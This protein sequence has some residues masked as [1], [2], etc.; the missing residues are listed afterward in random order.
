MIISAS[1]VVVD[2]YG[3]VLLIQRNDTWTLAPPGGAADI[4]ELPPETATR[5]VRE[6][7]GLIVTPVRLVGLYYL[8]TKPDS[9]LA[10][11]FRCIMRGGNIETSEESPH[12]GF[13]KTNPLPQ[14]MLKI[15]T[16]R[17]GRSMKHQGGAPYWGTDQLS[18]GMRLGK[19]LLNRMIYP[20]LN[21]R[22]RRAGLPMHSSPPTWQTEA[23]VVLP[24]DQNDIL[25]IKRQ[26]SNRW[27]LPGGTA[28]EEE[29]PWETAVRLI[30]GKQ[31][32]L[33][34]LSGV[35]P[36]PDNP[37][38]TFS[39]RGRLTGEPRSKSTDQIAYFR[40][41]EEPQEA[42]PQHVAF[43]ADAMANGEVTIFRHLDRSAA[44]PV[45]RLI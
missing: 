25:W 14:R 6:E 23:R 17:I 38:M 21:F 10:L 43:V 41:G 19:M 29:P 34:G 13:F 26:N 37:L 32:N 1:G 45:G 18:T 7:T 4:G 11:V 27:I 42:A 31:E 24:N 30:N 9:F 33:S 22:R 3:D 40:P 39:F 28:A 36:A 5:E 20:W 35:Y 2:H 44:L 12:V 8:P 16:E 15:H